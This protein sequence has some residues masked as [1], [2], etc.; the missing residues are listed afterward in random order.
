MRADDPA[1]AA[2]LRRT[3]AHQRNDV[4]AVGVETLR[5]TGVIAARTRFDVAHVDHVAEQF[6]LPGLRYR[7]ADMRA[8]PEIDP[9]HVVGGIVIAWQATQ[10]H[11]PSTEAQLMAQVAEAV[12][13]CGER[14]RGGRNGRKVEV[15][16]AAQVRKCRID[17]VEFG[18]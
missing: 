11:E 4:A 2:R 10:Q 6:A 7:R 8:K 5:A 18:R 13:E 12:A 14:E 15:T 3:Q 9:R 16:Q 1:G 17:L